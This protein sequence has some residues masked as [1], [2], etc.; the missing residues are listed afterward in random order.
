MDD[1]EFDFGRDKRFL[2]RMALFIG[3]ALLGGLFIMLKLTDPSVGGCAAEAFQ[4][5]TSGS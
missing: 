2:Y 1:D 3:I 4:S 5:V